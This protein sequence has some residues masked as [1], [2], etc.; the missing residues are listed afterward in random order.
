LLSFLFCEGRMEVFER[1]V[2]LVGL[3]AVGIEVDHLILAW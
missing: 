1:R 3:D 2:W